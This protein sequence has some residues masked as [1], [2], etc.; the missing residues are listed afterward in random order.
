MAVV[1]PPP[2][3]PNLDLWG[4]S[5]SAIYPAASSAPMTDIMSYQYPPPPSQNG[6]EMDIPPPGYMSNYSVPPQAPSGMDMRPSPDSGI[7]SRERSDSFSRS[8]KLKRSISTP[9]VG[10]PL[11]QPAAQQSPAAQ[12][13]T[14]AEQN[15]L[16]LAGEKRRNKLGYHRTSVAC[17]KFPLGILTLIHLRDWVV[18]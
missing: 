4:S 3:K 13:Q 12:Q 5:D 9:T 10:P 18:G 8:M 6:A 17:G 1:A 7:P 14:T 11:S 15:A 2:F 16:A